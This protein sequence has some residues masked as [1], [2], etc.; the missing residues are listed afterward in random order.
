LKVEIGNATLYLGDCREILPTLPRRDCVVTDPPY[1][2]GKA[3]WDD[4]FPSW[5]FELFAGIETIGLMPGVWN[6]LR[7]PQ[8]IGAARYRWTLAARLVNGMTR[9]AV[10][11]GNWIPML[12]YSARDAAEWCSRFADWC[13]A[14]NVGRKDLD[15][16][17]GTSDM[18]A[19]WASRLAR[20]SAIPTPSQWHRIKA[21]FKPPSE[22]DAAVN[23]QMHDID[24]DCKEFAVGSEKKVR[25][26]S[27][28][29]L[30]VTQWFVSRT[31]GVVVVDPFMGSGT[32]GV[33]CANLCRAFVGVETER[34]YFDL[35]CERIEAAHSQK[36]L[37]A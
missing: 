1:G 13:D 12:M 16:A 20:R 15:R 37:F 29:P 9:G 22:F 14:N 2:I 32:T 35:A 5:I 11:F 36:R 3:G 19:W 26:P 33:A 17:A 4:E 8:T 30:N 6:L 18:G 31:P 25:H 28:K 7:C 21:A 34:E 23:Q 27:Q 24:G 10:G